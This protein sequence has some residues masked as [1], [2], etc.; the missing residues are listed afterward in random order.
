[1][2]RQIETLRLDTIHCTS[3]DYTHAA[4]T[5]Y[6]S[7]QFLDCK[8]RHSSD[9]NLLLFVMFHYVKNHFCAHDSLN[10]RVLLQRFCK[11][12]PQH[13]SDHVLIHYH[14][15]YSELTPYKYLWQQSSFKKSIWLE[16]SSWKKTHQ[17]SWK[18]IIL[19]H[20]LGN[21]HKEHKS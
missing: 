18:K 14:E 2:F 1:M 4:A 11:Q 15:E 3:F 5:T 10:T 19:F 21:F 17:N 9:P 8:Y 6:W 13:L 16:E 12:G 7:A 20:L